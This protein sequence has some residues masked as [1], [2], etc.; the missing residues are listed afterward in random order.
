MPNE[1]SLFSFNYPAD[2]LTL[3][4]P[5][6]SCFECLEIEFISTIERAFSIE[7]GGRSFGNAQVTRKVLE[8]TP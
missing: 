7:L 1:T 8:L 6:S 2:T 4:E 5:A 3:A